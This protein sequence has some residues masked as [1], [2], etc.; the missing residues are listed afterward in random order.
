MSQV[1]GLR[2]GLWTRRKTI[3]TKRA[4]KA[5]LL[6]WVSGDSAF[7][8][9]LDTLNLKTINVT[10]FAGPLDISPWQQ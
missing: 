7:N 1:P 4:M 6:L 9:L 10:S 5:Y 2:Q 3:T 8:L